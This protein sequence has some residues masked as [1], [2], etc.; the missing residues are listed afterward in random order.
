MP[1]AILIRW[2]EPAKLSHESIALLMPLSDLDIL[3]PIELKQVGRL[4][5]LYALWTDAPFRRLIQ[6]QI[7]LRRALLRRKREN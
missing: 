3:K 5:F 1:T 4:N 6:R 7:P 2:P